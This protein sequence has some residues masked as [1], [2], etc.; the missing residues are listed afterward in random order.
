MQWVIQAIQLTVFFGAF[1]A[2]IDKQSTAA[3][4]TLTAKKLLLGS[5]GNMAGVFAHLFDSIFD[6]RGRGRPLF[7][8]SRSSVVHG[9]NTF[10]AELD[11]ISGRTGGTSF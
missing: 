8:S 7:F 6:P 5:V 10:F 11:P 4:N 9:A 2:W 1:G 3:Q